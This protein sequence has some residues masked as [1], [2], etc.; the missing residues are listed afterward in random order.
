MSV[1]KISI[2]FFILLSFGT[3][4]TAQEAIIPSW[5][6]LETSVI[7]V[8]EGWGIT[9]D[10]QGNVYWTVSTD[11]LNQGLDVKDYKFN[12]QGI[13]L[14]N[15][16]FL[17]GGPGT[18]HAYVNNFHDNHLYIGGRFCTGLINTCNMMLLKVNTSDQTLVWDRTFNFQSDGYDE[19]DG[20]VLRPDAIY[21]GGWG[22]ELQAGA[23]QSDIGLW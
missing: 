23:F 8:A 2:Q 13:E 1:M 6:K 14:W 11:E 12:A 4:V 9:T 15:Q 17:Y 19:V 18:Q 3:F 21:C 20:L 7:G 10:D 16:P 22:Q 5:M